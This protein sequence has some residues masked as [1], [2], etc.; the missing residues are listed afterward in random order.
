[1]LFHT[2]PSEP[3][4][5]TRG[6]APRLP[7][8]SGELIERTMQ[9]HFHLTRR[10]SDRRSCRLLSS[11]RLGPMGVGRDCSRADARLTLSPRWYVPT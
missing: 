2:Q 11:G 9:H 7:N 6:G 3:S 5:E 10:A 8:A 4:T 1:M